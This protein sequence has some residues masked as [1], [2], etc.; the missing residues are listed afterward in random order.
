MTNKAKPA[1]RIAALTF[2]AVLLIA[3]YALTLTALWTKAAHDL[4]GQIN[5]QSE[6]VSNLWNE[7][8][9]RISALR[10][11]GHSDGQIP[12]SWLSGL[13]GVYLHQGIA[14]NGAQWTLQ[15]EFLDGSALSKT[16]TVGHV[17]LHAVAQ[18]QARGDVLLFTEVQGAKGLF[19]SPIERINKKANAIESSLT[20]MT[21]S[22]IGQ[23]ETSPPSLG[24]SFHWVSALTVPGGA[25]L[26]TLVFCMLLMWRKTKRA[27]SPSNPRYIT[28]A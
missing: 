11:A 8:Q 25:L 9:V 23:R 6:V 27:Q 28:H 2:G 18:Y 24:G 20:G 4:V 22:P 19:H 3:A 13:D 10:T 14:S 5:G 16:L 15:Y 1:S 12:H 17:S 21:L 26:G 7:H